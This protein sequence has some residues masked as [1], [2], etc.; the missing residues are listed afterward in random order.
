M[1][2]TTLQ[3]F[4]Q[5]LHENR[6]LL[7]EREA[8]YG[9]IAAPV[10]LLNQIR[11]YDIAIERT[12]QA[13][14]EGLNLDDLQAEFNTLNLELRDR[15]VFVSLEPPRKPFTGQ[16]PYRGLEKFTENEA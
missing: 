10:Y 13:L 11:D 14:Q 1:A 2:Q 9:G 8:K 6:N 16:N 4:L 12:N 15:I 3:T 5:E 7:K